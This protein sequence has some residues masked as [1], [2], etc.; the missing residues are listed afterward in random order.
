[1]LAIS[2]LTIRIAG[3]LLIDHA[4][5]TVPSGARAGLI[6]RNGSGKTTLF[7]AI[8]GDLAPDTGSITIPKGLRL[9]QVAQ[10]APGTDEALIDIVLAADTERAGLLAAAESEADAHKIADIH[11]RLNDID[12][13]SGEARAATIL[14]GLG[15][16][17]AAQN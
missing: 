17:E 12:A 7:R 11:A 6:G 1:M 2:D 15:F 13:H 10:E 3:R 9:G 14:A 16:D 5:A 4:S 8:G